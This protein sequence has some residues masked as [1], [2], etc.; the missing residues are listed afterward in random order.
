M[1]P[2]TIYQQ[3]CL[4][5]HGEQLAGG[6]V[7]PNL[8]D[9][10]WIHGDGNHD[11]LVKVLQEGSLHKGMPAWKD[12]LS[13]LQINEMA[14]WISSQKGKTVTRA[15]APEGNYVDPKRKP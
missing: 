5:C 11:S 1:S 7:G 12:I 14:K 6:G 15:K 8:I 10:Y 2:Q 9:D 4:R 3:Y 13:D